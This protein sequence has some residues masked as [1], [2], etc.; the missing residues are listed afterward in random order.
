[1]NPAEATTTVL[2]VVPTRPLPVVRVS[3]RGHG[4]K[5]SRHWAPVIVLVVAD[6]L[7]AMFLVGTMLGELFPSDLVDR[8]AGRSPVPSSVSVP[9]STGDGGSVAADVSPSGR[10][11]GGRDG[12]ASVEEGAT[13]TTEISGSVVPDAAPTRGSDP[14]PGPAGGPAS[15]TT[16]AEAP[17]LPPAGPETTPPTA[18]PDST[19]PATE[20]VPD[21]TPSTIPE[22]MTP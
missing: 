11:G 9:P 22:E 16:T 3:H 17:V 20:P 21:T 15:I 7:V 2:A 1:M 10:P 6:A 5:P 19:P 13:S 14:G 18:P 12:G 8:S 4:P